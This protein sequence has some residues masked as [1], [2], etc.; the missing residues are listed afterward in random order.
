MEKTFEGVYGD[1]VPRPLEP[2]TI[3]NMQHVLVTNSDVPPQ[4]PT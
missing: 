4:P 1:G 3:A 2:L